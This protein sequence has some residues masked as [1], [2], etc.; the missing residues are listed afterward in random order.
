MAVLTKTFNK[1]TW[2]E[3]TLDTVY[4]WLSDDNCFGSQLGGE[5]VITPYATTGNERLEVQRCEFEIAN[6][7]NESTGAG[8]QKVNAVFRT[9]IIDINLKTSRDDS[10]GR[11][12]ELDLIRKCDIM[13]KYA[14]SLNGIPRL[15]G[16]GY[17]KANITGPIKQNNK[18]YYQRRFILSFQI[19]VA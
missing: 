7:L 5:M 15:G 4:E 2:E 13:D 6:I 14:R 12:A 10:G 19:E 16:A 3:S 8:R 11:S 9:V 18:Y 1:D 17:R